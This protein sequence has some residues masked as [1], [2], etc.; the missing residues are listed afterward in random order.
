MYFSLHTLSAWV[1]STDGV[2]CVSKL[3]K[4]CII[5]VFLHRDN[6]PYNR[7]IYLPYLIYTKMSS[8][9][10]Y[11]RRKIKLALVWIMFFLCSHVN[12]HQN[13]C[14]IIFNQNARKQFKCIINYVIGDRAFLVVAEVFSRYAISQILQ[15]ILLFR[16]HE[17]EA[18]RSVYYLQKSSDRRKQARGFHEVFV[19]IYQFHC[20]KLSL[21]LYFIPKLCCFCP[22]GWNH[23]Q[24][25]Y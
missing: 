23:F 1:L 25:P 16:T 2:A 11:M 22:L 20:Q 4:S 19:W 6:G 13:P 5:S 8:C 18:N 14:S 10:T 24:V 15:G 9:V 7:T 3:H 17:Y 21:P 12:Y